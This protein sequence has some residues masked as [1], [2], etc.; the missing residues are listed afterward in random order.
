MQI[1]IKELSTIGDVLPSGILML[2]SLWMVLIPILATLAKLLDRNT[3]DEP[4]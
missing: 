4:R 3:S 1:E 2:Q